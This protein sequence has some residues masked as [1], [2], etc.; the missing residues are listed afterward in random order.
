[1]F[2]RDQN[3]ATDQD[4]SGPWSG[5]FR[6]KFERIQKHLFDAD[7]ALGGSGSMSARYDAPVNI[8]EHLDYFELQLFAAG[9]KKELFTIAI[10]NTILSLSYEEPA[11]HNQSTFAYREHIPS[12]FKRN[13]LL[14]EQMLT[15]NIQA[16]FEEGVL[17]VILPKNPE[18][19][20]PARVV[21]I[22]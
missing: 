21:K 7:A 16:S 14:D 18:A 17:T 1:M 10:E 20:K 15:D 3:T 9:R 5:R 19:I 6:E 12:S 2:K 22:D 4:R 13:F 8:V 11:E